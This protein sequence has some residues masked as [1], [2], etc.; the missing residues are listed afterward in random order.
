MTPVLATFKNWLSSKSYSDSTLRNYLSDVNKY[1]SQLS[2]PDL[3]FDETSLSRYLNELSDLPDQVG[4]KYAPRALASL[5]K[6][7]QFALDQRLIS[8]NPMRN[9]AHSSTDKPSYALDTLLADYKS[10]LVNHHKSESTITNYINDIKQF[11]N[12]AQKIE[13]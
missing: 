2:S 5:S 10:Y 9:I 11:I 12:Y 13:T 6:F 7:C 3:A 8:V 1:L 4:K